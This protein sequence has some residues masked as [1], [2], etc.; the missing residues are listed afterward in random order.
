MRPIELVALDSVKDSFKKW[1]M[2][3]NLS[4]H[5]SC[6]HD[7]IDLRGNSMRDQNCV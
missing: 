5:V 7:L 1:G 6:I 3:G 2:R 4:D